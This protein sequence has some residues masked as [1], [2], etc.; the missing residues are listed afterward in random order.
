MLGLGLFL[1]QRVHVSISNGYCILSP[2]A[3]LEG[4]VW[5]S[6]DREPISWE[7]DI[8]LCLTLVTTKLSLVELGKINHHYHSLHRTTVH[9]YLPLVSIFSSSSMATGLALLYNC[10]RP[11]VS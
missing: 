1:G 2:R 4:S 3:A 7:L 5:G 11:A 6:L 10:A 9:F 8:T